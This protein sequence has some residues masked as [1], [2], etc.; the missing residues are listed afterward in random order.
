MALQQ[1]LIALST[2]SPGQ[3]PILASQ[4]QPFSQNDVLCGRGS[5]VQCHAGNE[6]YRSI[7]NDRKAEYLLARKGREKTQIAA[8]VVQA[9]SPQGGVFCEID[10][11]AAIQ[12]TK[13]ALRE[14]TRVVSV[15][16]TAALQQQEERLREL[17]LQQPAF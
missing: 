2:E 17:Q 16:R 11:E 9:E 13:Q 15:D 8:Q 14:K 12:K 6:R 1:Q 10:D 4:R 3:S 5:S 7:V